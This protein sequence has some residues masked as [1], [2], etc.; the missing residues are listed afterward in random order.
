MLRACF[1]NRYD[2]RQPRRAGKP[3]LPTPP[4]ETIFGNEAA[5]DAAFARAF[6]PPPAADAPTIMLALPTDS[7]RGPGLGPMEGMEDTSGA[8]PLTSLAEGSPASSPPPPLEG[9]AA[10]VQTAAAAEEL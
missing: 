9:V 2:A 7:G 8:P 6:R 5:A 4:L 3:S 10:E 1:P